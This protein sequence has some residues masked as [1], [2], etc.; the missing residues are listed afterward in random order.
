MADRHMADRHMAEKHTANRHI[1][2]DHA[3][4]AFARYLE[5]FDTNDPKIALKVRHTY[6]V[7]DAATYLADSE[8]LSPEDRDLAQ[9]IAL[10]HDIG[11]FEQL[12]VFHSYDDRNASHAS[13]GLQLL[14]NDGRIRDFIA[15]DAYDKIIYEAIRD[16]SLLAIAPDVTGRALLHARLVRDADKLDNFRVKTV[17]PVESMLDESAAELGRESVSDNIYQDFMAHRPIRRDDRHT[18]LDMWVSYLAFVYDFNFR[19][20]YTYVLDHDYLHACVARIPYATPQTAERM[21]AIE[22]EATAYCREQA[23]EKPLEWR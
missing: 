18:K 7:V 13:I 2:L 16:H 3:R 19:S 15:T 8:G 10:L 5:R 14:F 23:G 20:S 4:R 12:R 1:D 6:A 22:R 21:A 17:D 11:R 9:L